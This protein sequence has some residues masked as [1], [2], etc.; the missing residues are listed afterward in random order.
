M[1]AV[2]FGRFEVISLVG[3]GTCTA[4][5]LPYTYVT[6]YQMPVKD[7]ADESRSSS[8]G[9]AGQMLDSSPLCLS[10]PLAI[11]LEMKRPAGA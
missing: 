11:V 9:D 7:E 1:A 3:K 8:R 2:S 6:T 10:D 4:R 5:L